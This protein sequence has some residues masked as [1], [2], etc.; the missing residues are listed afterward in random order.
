MFVFAQELKEKTKQRRGKKA[1]VFR[2]VFTDNLPFSTVRIEIEKK[3][4]STQRAVNDDEN[5]KQ[6]RHYLRLEYSGKPVSI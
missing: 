1:S 3:N 4:C 2:Q 5:I 6:A